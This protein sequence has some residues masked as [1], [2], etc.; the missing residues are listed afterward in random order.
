MIDESVN[1][2]ICDYIDPKAF[3]RFQSVDHTAYQIRLRGM[4]TKIH[5]GKY[6]FLL[7]TKMKNDKRTWNN[8]PPRILKD[9][10]DF[11]I[12][13]L[14][15]NDKIEEDKLIIERREKMM[16]KNEKIKEEEMRKKEEI[17]KKEKDIINSFD[18]KIVIDEDDIEHNNILK[19]HI[20]THNIMYKN[21]KICF[22]DE[23]DIQNAE[24]KS[25]SD[26]EDNNENANKKMKISI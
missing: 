13:K 19:E 16:E 9:L 17:E 26:N 4:K 7:M 25:I 1:N 21:C 5:M 22:Y 8:I 10:P 23:E 11:N 14:N 3:E 6:D 15:E 12:G 2:K 18:E 24:Q 20:C